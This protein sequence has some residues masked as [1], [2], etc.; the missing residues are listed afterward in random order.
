MA[1][2]DPITTMVETVEEIETPDSLTIEEQVEIAAPGSFVPS[3]GGPVELIEQEDGGVIVDFDPSAMEV[4]ESDFFRNL[5]E[6]ID[7]GELGRISGDLLNE[8]QSN[9]MS[10]HDWEDTY[11][12][13][14]ELLGY[15]YEERTMPFRGATGVTHPLLAEAATQFQAQAFN[16]LLP[17][18]GPVR[19]TVMGERTKEKEQQA[20]RVREFMNYYITDVME[21]YTPE[22][23]Q[24]LFYLP[25]AGSTFKKVYY[26]EGLDRAVSKFVPAEQL[27]VPYETSNLETCPCITNVVPMDLNE[28]R[29]LQLS[30]FYRDIDILPSQLSDNEIVREQDKIQGVSPTNMEYDANLLEFHVDLDLPGFEEVD[31]ENEPTGIKIPYIVTIAE[32]ANK[33]LSVRR[34]YAEDDE[35]KTKI[36]YFVHYKFLPGFGFYGLGLIHAI[37]GLSRTATAALRQLIDA[38][39]L[40]NLPAGF[41]ARGL[42]VRDDADPL[43]PGE[44]RDV[45]APGGAIRDSLMPLPFKGPDRTLF[46]LLGFVVDAGQRFATITDLKVGDGNQQAAVGTTVAMLEQGSRV[47]SAVHKRMHYSMRKEFKVLARVMHESLPQE[48][49]FSVVGGDKSVMATDFDDRIDVLPVSNPNIFSQAQRIALA[50]AQLELAMQAPDMHNSHE[51]FRRMYEALGVRDIDKILNTPS[52]AQPVP[53]DPAQENIDALEKTDLEA[54]EGQNHDAHIMAHLTFGASPIVSQSPNIVTALQKHI[55]QHV[56]LKSQ[57]ITMVEFEKRANGQELSD[58]MLLEM[59]VYMA[60]LIAQELQQVRQLSQQIVNGPTGGEEEGPDPLIALKQQEIDI[61]GQKT[62]ADIANDQSKLT[63]EQQKMG[64]RSRQFDDRLES[65]Q[66]QTTERIEASDRREMMRLRQKEGK[67]P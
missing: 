56:K 22:F 19:T 57:E 11:S 33:I 60:Q 26:D 61:K 31:E 1:N 37:G 2:G 12:K 46:E 9:K 8:Y 44:F 16:E 65:Q 18:D 30:G 67:T 39:T 3:D 52:T 63:L 59:E 48:Y 51:A 34:N 32:D 15:V 23:D 66:N 36:Q 4:D 38:G 25:L 7:D 13:G 21:E 14:M 6:E 42:R 27:V 10:R 35:L 28:L 53:K 24:M 55:T 50:Q 64:E 58:E 47:M 17:A 62:Q 54:F 41:K 5:A 40:S 49:P 20:V 43:Q 29:K 45:D